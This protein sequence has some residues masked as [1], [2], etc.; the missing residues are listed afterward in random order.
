MAAINPDTGDI[1]D[2]EQVVDENGGGSYGW[3][4]TS[5]QWSPDGERLAYVRADGVGLVD[6]VSG[7]LGPYILDYDLLNPLGQDWSW[8]TTVSWTP[9]SSNLIATVH[10]PPIGSE[11]PET[12]P[13]FDIGVA[14]ADG[15]FV[16]SE[17]VSR[18]G[19]WST[20]RFSPEVFGGKRPP[21]QSVT[22][23]T[24]ERVSGRTASRVSM[25]SLSQTVTG[26]MLASSSLNPANPD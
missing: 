1:I 7:E 15:S 16:V 13:V 3:W 20:P 6:L 18:A 2:I 22:W 25:T 10:G 4:G 12:S 23:L 8:R 24:C 26:V 11:D 5:Y 21:S 19:I 9:D 14:A 17:L